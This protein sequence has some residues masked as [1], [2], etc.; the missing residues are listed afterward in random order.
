MARIAFLGL[1]LMGSGMASRL[2]RAGNEVSVWNRS[3]DKTE[4]LV[5]E[6]ILIAVS[7]QGDTGIGILALCRK[8]RIGYSRIHSFLLQHKHYFVK[9]T[10][11]GSTPPMRSCAVRSSLSPPQDCV[12][13]SGGACA[14]VP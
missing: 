5:A 10:G 3:P 1:G 2:L 4:P 7:D 11:N 14:E 12:P 9:I 6:E 13:G 8:T